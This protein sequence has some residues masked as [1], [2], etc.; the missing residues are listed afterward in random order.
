MN[1]IYLRFKMRGTV[2]NK[3][4][5]PVNIRF[6]DKTSDIRHLSGNIRSDVMLKRNPSFNELKRRD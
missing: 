6:V 3:T 1:L 5:N 4:Y 2:E